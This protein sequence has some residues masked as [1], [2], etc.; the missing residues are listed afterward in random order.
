[1][2]DDKGKHNPS[3]HDLLIK[4]SSDMSHVRENISRIND[5]LDEKYVTKEEFGPI[6][7]IVYALVALM[8]TG[9]VGAVI[10]LALQGTP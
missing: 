10:S 8:L 4:L 9:I 5:Q 1:M 3:D 2:A 7:K 6:Q